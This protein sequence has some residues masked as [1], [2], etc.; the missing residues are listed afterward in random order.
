M[1]TQTAGTKK[2]R[3]VRKDDTVKVLAGEFKGK[4]GKVVSLNRETQRAE[5]EIDG[6]DDDEKIMKHQKRS[7][8]F[9][10]GTILYLNPSIHVS[11]ITKTG[12]E[13]APATEE[14]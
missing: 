14:D 3:R 2:Q 6:I 1:A 4:T 8:E 7:N 11:N 12:T 13:A 5:V 10:N 9:P